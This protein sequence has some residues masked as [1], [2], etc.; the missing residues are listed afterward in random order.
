MVVLFAF[1]IAATVFWF[2][3]NRNAR[4]NAAATGPNVPAS[5]APNT[6]APP[7]NPADNNPYPQQSHPAVNPQGQP[8]PQGFHGTPEMQQPGFVQDKSVMQ[9]TVYPQGQQGAGENY[10]QPQQQTQT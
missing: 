3:Q 6:G 7:M 5:Q 9:Q 8:Q 1:T 4:R 2:V 10:N